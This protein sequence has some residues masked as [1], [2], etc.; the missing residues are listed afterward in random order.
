MSN[1][2]KYDSTSERL[3]NASL[4]ERLIK[5][6][7]ISNLL[8]EQGITIESVGGACVYLEDKSCGFKLGHG[9]MSW[10]VFRVIDVVDMIVTSRNNF[11]QR[12][13]EK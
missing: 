3:D 7:K 13:N 11:L 12:K 10:E 1:L 5:F 4:E 6:T 2:Q 8:E 9:S